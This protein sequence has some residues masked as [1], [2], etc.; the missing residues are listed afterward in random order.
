MPGPSPEDNQPTAVRIFA[1]KYAKAEE[2]AKTI[3]KAAPGRPPI[4]AVP[5]YRTNAVII[6]TAAERFKVVEELVK[7]LDAP[8]RDTASGHNVQVVI[9]KNARA[10]ELA[11]MLQPMVPDAIFA[12]DSLSNT[13]VFSASDSTKMIVEQLV[14][15]L[16]QERPGAEPPQG[17]K[18]RVVWLVS[19]L[20]LPAPPPDMKD[21]TEELA[22][23]GVEGLGL[24]AQSIVQ[25]V[26]S[27]KF[28]VQCSPVAFSRCRL[29]MKGTLEEDRNGPP[30]VEL[31]LSAM[32]LLQPPPPVVPQP[33]PAAGPL[34]PQPVLPSPGPNQL[35]SISTTLMAPPG[36][37]VVLGV[38]PIE[39]YTSVF[40]IQVLPGTSGK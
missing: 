31:T 22:T 24:G 35:A 29:E 16:D 2:V 40:V 9:L 14:Q 19:G 34:P 7:L 6:T 15:R 23:M 26:S 25:T 4:L 10:S 32:G 21:V 38:S 8:A 11:K 28:S 1:L 12:A 30:R 27:G 39:K 36:H 33:T 17:R 37:K 5:D 3:S 18:V 20:D 13:L